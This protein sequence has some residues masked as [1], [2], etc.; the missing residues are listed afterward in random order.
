MK[1]VE[2]VRG[3]NDKQLRSC[4]KRFDLNNDGVVSMNEI[5]TVIERTG[6]IMT[7]KQLEDLVKSS[8]TFFFV[9]LEFLSEFHIISSCSKKSSKRRR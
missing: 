9:W 1:S 4:F 8:G 5:R 2:Y 3:F 6:K 7:Q